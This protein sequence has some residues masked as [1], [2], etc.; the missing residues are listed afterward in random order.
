MSTAQRETPI[1]SS[2]RTATLGQYRIIAK[3]GTGGMAEVYLAVAQG[4][5]NVNRLVVVKRLREEQASDPES[6]EMF[7]NEARLAARLNHPNVIQ[8]FEA[9]AEAGSYYLAMEY[10]EGQPFSRVLSKMMQEKRR[11]EPKLV[12]RI[13]SDALSGLH[14]AHELTDFDGSPLQIVHRDVSPQNMMLTYGGVTKIVDFGIAKAAG[15]TQ[16]AHGVFKGK[17]AFMAPEQVVG[18]NVDGRADVFAAGIVLWEALTGKHLMAASTPAHTL[19]NLLNRPIPRASEM[20]PEVPAALDDIAARALERDVEAR[21]P[22]AKAMRDALEAWIGTQGGVTHEEV[23]ALVTGLFA[24]RRKTV[25]D[26]VKAQLAALSLTRTSE[27]HLQAAHSFSTTH[28]RTAAVSAKVIDLSDAGSDAHAS[29]FRVVS[30]NG[31]ARARQRSIRGRV[32][33]LAVTALALGVSGFAYYRSQHPVASSVPTTVITPAT[34]NATTSNAPSASGDAASAAATPSTTTTTSATASAT[35]SAIAKATPTSE[36]PRG[37]PA[38]GRHNAP[39]SPPAVVTTTPPAPAP[40]PPHPP[41]TASAQP[42]PPAETT[43]G[44]TFRRDL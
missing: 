38:L 16:T 6:R 12:A 34:T 21:F 31:R 40:P 1:P 13:I 26:Q 41:A 8:T 35:A 3:L 29:V 5:M 22:S 18:E 19:H 24:D 9:G 42:H 25:Q 32:A 20:C 39:P 15:S 10:V 23:G 2:D 36:P 17:V 28:V 7:L 44:R 37:A 11:L 27:P 30:T 43:Q 14:Y 4:A 33:L